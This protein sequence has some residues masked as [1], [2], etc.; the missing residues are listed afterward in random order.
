MYL[1]GLLFVLPFYS[2]TGSQQACKGFSYWLQSVIWCNLNFSFVVHFSRA[3][4]SKP[5]GLHCRGPQGP[6]IAATTRGLSPS[7]RSTERRRKW[8]L[9]SSS[10][11]KANEARASRTHLCLCRGETALYKQRKTNQAF[12]FEHLPLTLR[13]CAGGGWTRIDSM[14]QGDG[15]SPTQEFEAYL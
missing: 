4:C 15:K 2:H 7:H 5:R 14:A 3:S 9:E 13:R 11:A 1:I 8:R 6:R 12:E 10:A